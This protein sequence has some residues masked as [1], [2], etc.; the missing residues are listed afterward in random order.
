MA[1]G[2]CKSKIRRLYWNQLIVLQS[3]N[4][5]CAGPAS[6]NPHALESTVV[7]VPVPLQLIEKQVGPTWLGG[8]LTGTQ[9]A[10]D[11]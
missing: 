4:P 3:L 7:C 6:S 5:V 9:T 1:Q 2:D 10:V 8:Q 11:S